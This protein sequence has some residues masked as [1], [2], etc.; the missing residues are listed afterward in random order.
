MSTEVQM[1]VAETQTKNQIILVFIL[2]NILVPI[3]VAMFT[4]YT[5]NVSINKDYVSLAISIVQNDKSKP[6]SRKWAVEVLNSLAPIKF[7]Q[8][9]IEEIRVSTDFSA[10][11]ISSTPMAML[12]EKLP[13]IKGGTDKEIALHLVDI[14]SKYELCA[15]IHA[16]LVNLMKDLEKTDA[17]FEKKYKR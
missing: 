16:A 3:L 7:S 13:K 10:L 8:K 17:E 5:G 14:Y 9:F 2:S 6:E 12:C 15:L 4:V 1:H 11:K